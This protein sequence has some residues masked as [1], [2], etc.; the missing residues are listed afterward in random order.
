MNIEETRYQGNVNNTPKQ[1]NKDNNAI[2]DTHLQGSDQPAVQSTAVPSTPNGGHGRAWK[3]VTIGG[4]AGILM[5]GGAFL[6]TQYLDAAE[7]NEPHK[8]DD[9]QDH[10]DNS[11]HQDH[12]DLGRTDHP[13]GHD[14]A[15]SHGAYDDMSFADAFDAARTEVGSGGL[16]QWHGAVFNTYTVDEWNSLSDAERQQFA[17]N[18][19]TE[20][21]ANHVDTHSIADASVS[22]D[23]QVDDVSDDNYNI[24]DNHV[25]D[26]AERHQIDPNV[27]IVSDN[28]DHQGIDFAE[29]EGDGVRIIAEQEVDGHIA[30]IYDEN[31]DD[32]IDFAIVDVDDSHDITPADVLV[33]E[34]GS[35]TVGDYVEQ[36]SKE[37]E[38]M[39]LVDNVDDDSHNIPTVDELAQN[40]GMD[41]GMVD[42]MNDG[43]ADDGMA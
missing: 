41:D 26:D 28:T 9:N 34:E 35:I 29:L 25:M 7:T 36:V 19:H 27:N 42:Y 14:A 11:N 40:N 16:F 1:D 15:I 12:P 10:Q 24:A 38:L 13:V 37:Q 43:M 39:V 6:A 33:T 23:S 32:N 17:D 30:V 22:H 5:G 2:E 21:D 8:H 31:G 20:V 18:V 4:V 3:T